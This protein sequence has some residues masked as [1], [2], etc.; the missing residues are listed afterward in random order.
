M[1][2]NESLENDNLPKFS[3]A[4]Q[5]TRP[6]SA[7]KT[8]SP[9]LTNSPINKIT[10][11]KLVLKPEKLSVINKATSLSPKEKLQKSLHGVAEMSLLP[12]EDSW[13]NKKS[14]NIVELETKTR[15]SESER[16]TLNQQQSRYRQP[17]ITTERP[18]NKS[19]TMNEASRREARKF[20]QKQ[21]E[22]RKLETKKEIDQSFIIKQRLDELRKTVKNVIAKKPQKD[23]SQVNISPPRNYYSMSNHHMKEIKV[24]KLKPMSKGSQKSPNVVDLT[25]SG[26]ERKSDEIYVPKSSSP[27]KSKQEVKSTTSSPIKPAIVLKKPE[28]PLKSSTQNREIISKVNKPQQRVSQSKENEDPSNN[29]KLK[30]PDV[31]LN[32]KSSYQSNKEPQT[33]LVTWLQNSNV[34][35]YP[36]NFIYA[37]RKKLQAYNAAMEI[38]KGKELKL[39]K[40]ATEKLNKNSKRDLKSRDE[41]DRS[42]LQLPVT[43]TSDTNV[44]SYEQELEANT[45]SEV[46]SLQSDMVLV[47]SKSEENENPADNDADTTISELIF[48]SL[49]DDAFIG[50]KR[51]SLNSA[52]DRTSFDKKILHLKP[53]E[54]SPNT[55]EKQNKFLSAKTELPVLKKPEII[56]QNDFNIVEN[57]ED[58]QKKLD[59][60]NQSLS[61]VIQYNE[62][63]TKDLN[64]KSPSRTSETYHN[65]K[66]SFEDNVETESV[67]TNVTAQPPTSNQRQE[68][69]SNSLIKTFIEDSFKTE[70]DVIEDKVIAYVEPAQD[71]SSNTAKL[72]ATNMDES[73]LKNEKKEELETTFEESKLLNIF[74]YN[75]SETSF[76]I[77]LTD[78]NESFE[79]LMNQS[80]SEIKSWEKALIDRARGQVAW[81]ELQKQQFKKHGLMDKV[82]TIRKK[83]RAILLRLEKERMKRKEIHLKDQ[84]SF[85]LSEINARADIERILQ[86][87][88]QEIEK[89]RDHIEHLVKWQEKLDRAEA[90]LKQMEQE[91]LGENK[92]KLTSS[93][94][95]NN[96]NNDLLD[97]SLQMVKSIDKSLKV[98]KNIQP[99]KGDEFVEVSGE[100][101]NKLWQRLTG[102]VQN[103][104]DPIDTYKLSKEDFAKFY[105]DAKEVVL[106]SD[107]KVI[108]ESSVIPQQMSMKNNKNEEDELSD[109]DNEH[110]NENENDNK[111]DVSTMNSIMNIETEEEYPGSF[112]YDHQ[113]TVT[114]TATETDKTNDDELRQML[115]NQM[116]VFV[117]VKKTEED[118]ETTPIAVNTTFKISGESKEKSLSPDVKSDRNSVINTE[119]LL[120]VKV[121]SADS[122][123]STIIPE[124]NIQITD[125]DDDNPI[126]EEQLIEDISFPNL[127]ISGMSESTHHEELENT[128]KD[129]STIAECSEFEHSQNTSDEEISSEVILSRH[130]NATTSTSE[131][132][133]NSEIERRLSSITDSLE[134]VNVAFKK[135]ALINRSPSSITYSTDKDFISSEKISTSTEKSETRS[136]ME[137]GSQVMTST[138]E[139]VKHH[140]D[141]FN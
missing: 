88:E 54:I 87:R 60:F 38:K 11:A 127:D 120:S 3:S 19:T 118:H 92:K 71:V 121:S 110:E 95:K 55:M 113:E 9:S 27:V 64:S 89:R 106:R 66:S 133:L 2:L 41:T 140:S 17:S 79:N 104:Y 45:I 29:I 77:T 97:Q 102:L 93:P 138:P 44:T 13:I 52:F 69:E 43:K 56:P 48:Q 31:K 39:K 8:G 15:K 123:G 73:S 10:V 100:K 108:L 111:S 42:E 117:D 101:L 90:K 28:S 7:S 124:V 137:S 112:S 30:V 32:Y 114:A 96:H 40:M 83:Q 82:S 61:N 51:E 20:M 139:I 119:S 74:K 34:Q 130:S 49:N 26:K 76:N 70:G 65:Y 35:P 21:R 122:D 134:E 25:P 47:K 75:E 80:T 126:H 103:I 6:K 24:L 98:L 18:T 81:L 84:D 86:E 115:E 116:K 94:R 125:M 135:I 53:E 99:V 107:M 62:R 105:E 50:K 78:N 5:I 109:S 12:S 33:N 14:K 57:Q 1:D 63:L 132:N 22:K 37:V 128:R 36:Y 46:S 16:K 85:S 91:L 131:A 141:D 23:K 129:L 72:T 58:Y 4:I 59:E 68:S 67:K 136:E